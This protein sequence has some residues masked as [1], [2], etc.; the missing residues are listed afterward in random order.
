MPALSLALLQTGLLARITRST[1]LEVLRQDYIRTARAKGLPRRLVVVKH[2]LSN[3]LIPITTVVGIIISLLIS[4]AVVIE[5]LFSIP[6]MGQLADPG[7]AEPRLSDGAGRAVDDHDVAGVGE[8]RRGHR[9][10]PSRPAGALSS[11]PDGVIAGAPLDGEAMLEEEFE[12]AV[13]RQ[14]PWRRPC[15]ACSATGFS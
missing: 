12:V 14:A 8:Y 7:G 6:G 1:M 3:A 5:S 11:S 4:G 9:L 2:A 10:C 13:Q 15:G